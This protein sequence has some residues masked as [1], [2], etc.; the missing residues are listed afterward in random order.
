VDQAKFFLSVVG[1]LGDSDLPPILDLEVDGGLSGADQAIAALTWLKAVEAAT[2]KIPIIYA[3]P[4]FIN[5]MGNP[6]AFA[7][8]PLW[9]ANYGVSQ[10]QIIPPWKNWV[11]WQD[12]ENGVMAGVP[13]N[14]D[15]D[16]FNGSSAELQAFAKKK[17]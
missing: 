5:A 6:A 17:L 16:W 4:D 7:A 9:I 1:T 2:G 11:F 14:V 10:P 8:Y 3:S 15:T 13:G 12:S